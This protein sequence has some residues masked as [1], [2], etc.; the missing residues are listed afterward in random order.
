MAETVTVACKVPNG[1]HM[2]VV[3]KD[4]IKKRATVKGFARF[5]GVDEIDPVVRVGGFGLTPNVDKAHA[6]AWFA[7]NKDLDVVKKGLIF[8]SS[9]DASAK[10]QA[11]EMKDERSG[12][13]P[14]NPSDVDGK[15]TDPRLTPITGVATAEAA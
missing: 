14:L 4:G 1:I 7:Q 3:G 13:E 12:F 8:I 9:S 11:K 5:I 10:S 2:D 6:E 15:N